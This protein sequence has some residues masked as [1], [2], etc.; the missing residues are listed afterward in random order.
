MTWNSLPVV[1]RRMLKGGIILGGSTMIVK[2]LLG[3]IQE[4]RCARE[5][6]VWRRK[7]GMLA[8]GVS[9]GCTVG[10]VTGILF[11]PK[12]GAETREEVGRRSRETL[13]KIKNTALSSGH[14][15]AQAM[16]EKGTQVY[17][18]AEKCVNAAKE[19]LHEPDKKASE[20]NPNN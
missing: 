7:A 1:K 6:E 19:V 4:A 20:N 2:E 17:G 11:A 18:A 3:R 16:E 15:L 12:T 5:K 9:I 14:R 10:A 13:E 8:L